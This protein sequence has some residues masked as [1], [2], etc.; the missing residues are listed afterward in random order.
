MKQQEIDKDA[1]KQQAKEFKQKY[2][3]L[4]KEALQYQILWHN[5]LSK[6]KTEF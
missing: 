1:V 6:I 5:E 3:E 4:K 2:D